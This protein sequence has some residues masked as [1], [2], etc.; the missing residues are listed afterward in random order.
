MLASS[1]FQAIGAGGAVLLAQLDS[2]VRDIARA[3][4]LARRTGISAVVVAWH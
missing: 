2:V 4:A 1:H 3:R